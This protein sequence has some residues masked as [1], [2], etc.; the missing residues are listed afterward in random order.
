MIKRIDVN[1][2]VQDRLA[3]SFGLDTYEQI[4]RSVNA[5]DVSTDVAFQ[6]LFNGF[7]LVRRNGTWRKEYYDLFESKKDLHPSFE[8]II[9]V[10]HAKTGKIEASF[11]SKMIATLNPEMPIWDQFVLKNLGLELTGTEEERLHHAI[12][13]YKEIQSWYADYLG[14]DD[15][16]ECLAEFDRILPKYS[17]LSDVK[18]I[19]CFL[20]SMR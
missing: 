1:R 18:K 14:T 6:R 7:Y 16:R 11:S 5:I 15:A 8:E 9:T 4:M 19:D 2:I 3:S 17:W 13:L 12:A 10:L 20:W